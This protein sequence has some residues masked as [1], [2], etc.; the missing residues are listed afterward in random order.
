MKS[1]SFFD[2]LYFSD[3]NYYDIAAVHK[4]VQVSKELNA[5]YVCHLEDDFYFYD[6]DFLDCCYAFLE[7]NEDCGYLRIL[8]YDYDNKEIYDN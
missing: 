3:K 2:E 6:Y 8:K 4:L 5:E 1:K 7:K